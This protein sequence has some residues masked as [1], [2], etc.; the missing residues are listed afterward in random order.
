MQKISTGRGDGEADGSGGDIL[1]TERGGSG[2]LKGM[3]HKVLS[4]SG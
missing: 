1:A 4:L 3:E 2:H